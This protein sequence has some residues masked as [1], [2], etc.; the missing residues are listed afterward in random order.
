M[1]PKTIKDTFLGMDDRLI[2]AM[3]ADDNVFSTMTFSRVEVEP[4]MQRGVEQWA[5]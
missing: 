2:R 5:P 1:A 3:V 4:V